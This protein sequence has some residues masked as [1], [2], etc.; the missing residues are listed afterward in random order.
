MVDDRPTAFMHPHPIYL[1]VS[2]LD[3]VRNIID[4]VKAP[5]G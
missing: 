2:E 5:V 4:R 1:R 3:I